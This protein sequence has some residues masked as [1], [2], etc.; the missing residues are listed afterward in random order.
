MG[1]KLI[2]FV[3]VVESCKV[4]FNVSII[5]HIRF[6]DSFKKQSFLIADKNVYKRRA[7]SGTHSNAIY[8][9]AHYIIETEFNGGSSCLHQL[10][11]ICTR[12]GRRSN[13]AIISSINV[14]FNDLRKSNVSK[15]AADVI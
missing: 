14:D 2:A 15:K 13:L 9:P 1:E 11:E 12:K 7:K 5:I 8:L 6:V 4:I 3:F 10:N